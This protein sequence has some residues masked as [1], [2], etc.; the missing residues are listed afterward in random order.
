[1]GSLR[2]A[3]AIGGPEPESDNCAPLV[4][5]IKLWDSLALGKARPGRLPVSLSE[6]LERNAPMSEVAKLQIGEL[7]TVRCCKN[8]IS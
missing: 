8:R 3:S 5:R 1:M 6:V 4:Q 2:A 7:H